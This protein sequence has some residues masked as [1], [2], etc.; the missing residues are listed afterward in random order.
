VVL[1]IVTLTISGT[2]P[3]LF[4]CCT[5]ANSALLGSLR[6]AAALTVDL[7]LLLHLHLRT[8]LALSTAGIGITRASA[9]LQITLRRQAPP[10]LSAQLAAAGILTRCSATLSLRLLLAT[11]LRSHPATTSAT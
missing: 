3:G 7:V 9:V 4:H 8:L 10:L 11:L 2:H 1:R 5:D 6:S